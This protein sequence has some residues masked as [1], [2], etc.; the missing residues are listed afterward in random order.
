MHEMELLLQPSTV[1]I[2]T[3]GIRGALAAFQRAGLQR[4]KG[5][6]WI[7]GRKDLS[8]LIAQVTRE[9]DYHPVMSLGE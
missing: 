1:H 7:K 3:V 5:P 6:D 8:C 4:V 2:L 9:R